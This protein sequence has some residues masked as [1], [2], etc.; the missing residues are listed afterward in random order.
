MIKLIDIK[1]RR[2]YRLWLK[3]S[4]G[5]EGEIDLHDLKGKGVFA[6]WEGE[7]NFEKVHIGEFGQVVW[8]EEL[9]MCADALYLKLTGRRPEDLFPNLKDIVASH[10]RA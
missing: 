5:S 2:P 4:D 7:G 1:A 10:A 8:S 3:Y 6:I 9:E